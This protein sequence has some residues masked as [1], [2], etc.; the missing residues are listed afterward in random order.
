[1]AV[2]SA[3]TKDSY[4]PGYTEVVMEANDSLIFADNTDSNNT[5]RDTVQGLLD[6]ATGAPSFRNLII[7]GDMAIS[8]RG[9][10]FVAASSEYLLD[11]Y[12][13][14]LSGAGVYTV[15]QD[16]DVPNGNFDYSLKVDCTTADVSVAA[17][18]YYWIAQKI[19]GF[20]SAQLGWGTADNKA[21]TI[22]FWVK[23]TKTG[24]QV[25]AVNNKTSGFGYPAEYTVDTTNTWEYKTVTIPG[26]ASG[27]WVGGNDVGI[28]VSFALA[29][30]SDRQNTA[31][32]WSASTPYTYG[33]SS[34]V[35]NLDN[36]ANNFYITGVQLEVGS[37]AT[38]FEHV[39]YDYQLRRCERYYQTYG[40]GFHAFG[41]SASLIDS[42]FA[43][44]Q[45][46][47]ASPS[48][49]LLDTTPT[50]LQLNVAGRTGTSSSITT[51]TQGPDGTGAVRVDGFSSV[52]AS[53]VCIGN[54]NTP[55]FGFSAEL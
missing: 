9:T 23:A 44:R 28:T 4:I 8:Q 40:M 12:H 17:G 37:S 5:K 33:T 26:T 42:Q 38:D 34:G 14:I 19:E 22:S 29:V 53:S 6:L 1:N 15:T 21:V 3:H 39:P 16:T 51:S 54:Q 36:T 35:N 46:M 7:N 49:T 48:V 24:T 50:F 2:D 45:T 20:N 30:G 55:I 47:R 31:D 27:T 11:R 18:D 52:G 13:T 10:T 41:I 32:T 43:F 25:V